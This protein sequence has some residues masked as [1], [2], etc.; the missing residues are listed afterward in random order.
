MSTTDT[1]DATATD[2]VPTVQVE[3]ALTDA[4]DRISRGAHVATQQE[5]DAAELKARDGTKLRI[6]A[7]NKKDNLYS[8]PK[9]LIL[10]DC[11]VG[12]HHVFEG[13]KVGGNAN[14]TIRDLRAL[15]NS[16][17]ADKIGKWS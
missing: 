7:Q 4:L 13:D 3:T 9:A 8:S 11:K 5:Q 15:V 1:P 12:P 10:Q 6:Q 2:T 17:L 16:G 14:V